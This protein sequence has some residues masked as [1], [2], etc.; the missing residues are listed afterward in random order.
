MIGTSLPEYIFIRVSIFLLQYTTPICLAYVLLII[1]SVGL[2]EIGPQVVVGIL[3]GYSVLDAFYALLVFYPY[4]RRLKLRAEHPPLKSKEERLKLFEQVLNNIPDLVQYLRGWFLGANE[5]DIWRDNVYDFASWAFFDRKLHRLTLAEREE[6]DEYI[7]RLEQR[8]GRPLKPGRNKTNSLRLTFDDVEVR[9]RSVIWYFIVGIVDLVTYFRLRYHGLKFHAQAKAH[10]QSVI[11]LRPQSLFIE[12]RSVARLS[13]WYRPHTAENKLPVIF[14]HGI[15][16]GLWPYVSYLSGLNKGF[17]KDE[18]IGI[19]ALEILPVSFR[20][21]GAPLSQ[22]EFISEI[23]LILEEHG[24]DQFAVVGHSY[25]TVLAAHMVKSPSLNPRIKSLML[26]DPVCILLHLPDV[27][28]NFTRRKPTRANEYLLWYFASMDPGVA[29]CL[30]RHFFWKDNIAWKEE[31]L[32]IV[33]EQVIEPRSRKVVVCLAERDLIVDTRTVQQYLVNGK[34]WTSA[35][36]GLQQSNSINATSSSFSEH[37]RDNNSIEVI[38][39]G[40]LDHAQVFDKKETTA[41][42]IDLTRLCCES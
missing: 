18:K 39:F 12:K 34:D 8:L 38:W 9:Y 29:H 20:L 35:S 17:P 32:E 24:W 3:L 33:G 11:P 42:I 36:N 21:T 31:L 10:S 40:G 2:S 30:G 41:Q 19:I 5:A 7:N 6:L 26:I 37:G 1:S 15:G 4:N 16:I 22:A 28:V 14:L 13:Y 25:G 23:T 27:A